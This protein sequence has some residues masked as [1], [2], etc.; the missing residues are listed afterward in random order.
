MSQFPPLYELHLP[1]S[2]KH[3]KPCWEKGFLLNLEEEK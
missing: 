3:P 2:T 1:I